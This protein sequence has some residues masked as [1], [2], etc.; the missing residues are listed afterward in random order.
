MTRK[1]LFRYFQ[2]KKLHSLN[3]ILHDFR[4]IES[5]FPSN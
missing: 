3:K 1:H 5:N 4:Q 2:Q